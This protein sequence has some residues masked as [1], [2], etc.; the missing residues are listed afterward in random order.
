M[1]KILIGL[2]AFV[3][4]AAGFAYWYWLN[5]KKK[6][7][8]DLIQQT[9]S[10]KTDSLYYLRYDSSMIDELNGHVFFS[11]VYLQSDSEQAAMLKSNDSLPNILINIFVRSVEASGIDMP[12]YVNDKVVHAEKI[13]LTA[14]RVRIINTGNHLLKYEDT[15]AVYKKL[16]GEFKSIRADEIII[17]DAVFESV[18][19][20]EVTQTKVGKANIQLTNF[21]VDSTRDY[22]NILSY[23]IDN[24]VAD[25]DS[26]YINGG[27]GRSNVYFTGVDYNTHERTLN[28]DRFASFAAG[29]TQPSTYLH[30]LHC[31]D[32]DVKAFILLH[33]LRAG[34]ISSDGGQISIFTV[35]KNQKTRNLQNKPFEFPEAFF[36]EIEI[37]ALQLGSTTLWIKNKLDP[38]RPPVKVN[39]FKFSV[40]NEINVANGNTVRQLID[41]A[42][43]TVSADGLSLVSDDGLYTFLVSGIALEHN[44]R[45]A[46]IKKC[47]V[48][49]NLSESEFMRRAVKQCDYY[50]IDMH[51]IRLNGLD[52]KKL[53]NE[54]TVDIE[55]AFLQ[56]NLRVFNDRTL[57]VNHDSKVGKY[58]HQLL[59]KLKIPIHIRQAVVDNTSISYRERSAETRD[60]GNVLFT[61][62]K[63]SIDNITNIPAAIKA[64]PVLTLRGSGLFL[65][66]SACQTEWKLRL[67]GQR[68]EFSMSGHVGAMDATAFNAVSIPLGMTSVNGRVNDVQYVMTGDDYQ[69]KGKLTLLYKDLKIETFQMDD[70][71]DSLK[72][73]KV[74]SLFS[75]ALIKNNNPANGVTRSAEFSHQRELNKSFFNHVWKSVFDG[76]GKTVMGKGGL[77]IQKTLQKLKKPQKGK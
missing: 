32:L 43:W 63:G 14:P 73:K 70:S 7:V 64:N 29:E 2:L 60:V 48:K 77:E 1:K 76:I 62:V 50:Q 16:V 38:S 13:M 61:Q 35:P 55:K 28:I 69:S 54:S 66:K 59:L 40:N 71:G 47:S 17:R 22:S 12:A 3:L 34:K 15:L 10:D 57:P 4:I 5:H 53:L 36:D 65:N 8:K 44:T 30:S 37:G 39:N 74:E 52:I 75:N 21:R 6:I 20:R 46:S 56:L 26:I 24:I 9:V 11:N 45:N 67:D 31:G 41:K 19:R 25:V 23:F 18:N 51:N 42:D 27:E 72:S 58:P 49:P 33:T 68:G